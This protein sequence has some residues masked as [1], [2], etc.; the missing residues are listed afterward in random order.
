MCG[1]KLVHF[2]HHVGT[3]S[4]AA[5]EATAVFK[6]LI[7]EYVESAK[8]GRRPPDAIVRSHRH[9]YIMCEIPTGRDASVRTGRTST[10]HAIAAVTGC[11]QGKT[12]FVWKIAG[13]RLTTPQFGGIVVRYSDEELFVRKRIWTVERSRVE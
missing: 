11:W 7:E 3:T 2:L 6:E 1:P 5:Y 10:G 4:S 13:A 12:P 9:R 8:W